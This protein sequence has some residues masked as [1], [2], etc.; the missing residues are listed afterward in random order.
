MYIYIY[1]YIYIH[2]YRPCRALVS[3]KYSH[4]ASVDRLWTWALS[5]TYH[6]VPVTSHT[7]LSSLSNRSPSLTC[8]LPKGEKVHMID[9][10]EVA[11][12]CIQNK[13]FAMRILHH[14]I[15]LTYIYI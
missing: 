13:C 5:G 4:L 7:L 10:M 2:I 3:L 1:I 6:P 12:L 15:L 8:S 9:Q 14:T 11:L